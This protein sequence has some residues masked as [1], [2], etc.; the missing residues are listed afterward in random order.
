[1]N[2][3]Q[4]Y[5]QIHFETVTKIKSFQIANPRQPNENQKRLAISLGY[6]QTFFKYRLCHHAQNNG[7][8]IYYPIIW[9]NANI[10]L[11]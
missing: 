1:M 4:N 7:I 9:L 3:H 2:R 8:Y 5:F 11:A 6:I 10:N